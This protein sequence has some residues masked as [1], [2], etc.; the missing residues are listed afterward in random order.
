[1]CDLIMHP[2]YGD[3]MKMKINVYHVFHWSI[4]GAKNAFIS[5]QKKTLYDS[6]LAVIVKYT[7]SYKMCVFVYTFDSFIQLVQ[8]Y[9]LSQFNKQWEQYQTI[10]PASITILIQAY[11]QPTYIHSTNQLYL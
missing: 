7:I 8:L 2:L 6:P 4:G 11:I 1:M 9:F 3:N 5:T 10:M